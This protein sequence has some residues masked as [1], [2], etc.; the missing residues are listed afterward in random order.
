MGNRVVVVGAGIAGLAAASYLQ[1]NGFE[2]S[3]YELHDKPGGL[4][5]A[6]S[7]QGYTFDGCIHWLMGSGPS[8]NLHELWKELGAGEL[9]YI[10]WKTYGTVPLAGGDVFTIYTDPDE[11]A[12]EMLRLNPDDGRIIGQIRRKIAAV[13]RM[14]MPAAYDKVPAS[15]WPGLL[16]RLAPV[17]P[18]LLADTK[19]PLSQLVG[20]LKGPMLKEAFASMY[21]DA[22]AFFPAAALYMMLG[23]MAKKSAGYPLGGSLKFARA[24]EAKYLS[25]GGRIHYK[26]K[27][28]E[29]I[30]ADGRA[31]GI[32][33]GA[34]V[35]PA[36]IVVSAADGYDTLKRLLGDRY[37]HPG[38]DAA[39][40]GALPPFPSLLFLSLGLKGEFAGQSHS[41]VVLFKQP[42]FL[43]GGALK[44]DRMT[45]RLFNFDRSMSPAGKTAA[46][47]MIETANDAYW[48]KLK[49]SDPAGYA[50][51]KANAVK[52]LLAA[53]ADREPE[54][55][56]AVEYTDLATPDTF[57]RYTNNWRGSY[58]GWLPKIGVLGK[59]VAKTVPG[60]AGL[61]LVG[62]WVNPGGGL[63]PCAMDGRSLAKK[64][65][66]EAG[67]RFKAD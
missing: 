20:R 48:T 22:L 16:V 12:A 26:R 57:I 49:A 28:D 24:I 31:V 25:L 59:A 64:L 18:I 44:V 40:A 30:V 63:P 17:L 39:F 55:A 15:A 54:L 65:A 61:H 32:R 6:W 45:V 58:E 53:L 23:F 14:D 38:L 52:A 46:I 3:I 36:D 60:V 43:E 51:A 41:R 33:I 29:I 47:A 2:T 8:S 34:E 67:R 7:R 5:T 35:V 9:E 10:E 19:R 13:A 1:R 56:A 62:Q 27:V 11:L 37:R 66:R 42:V 4:C 50:A 21:G